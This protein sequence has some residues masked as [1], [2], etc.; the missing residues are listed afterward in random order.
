MVT[1]HITRGLPGCG[2]STFA[3]EWV[4]ENPE[5]RV[6]INLDDFRNMFDRYTVTSGPHAIRVVTARNAAVVAMLNAG[7]DVIVDDT[8]LPNKFV[9]ELHKIAVAADADFNVVDMT[10]V[11]VDVCIARDAARDRTVGEDVIRNYHNRFVKGRTYPLKVDIPESDKPVMAEPYIPDT[12]LPRTILCD[13]DGTV[14]LMNGRGP[15][16]ETRVSEDLPN[17]PV[18]DA[19]KAMHAAGHTVVFLSARTEGCKEDTA[20]WLDRHVGITYDNLLMR[21]VGDQR[22]DA[23]VKREIFDSYIRDHY[24]VIGVFDDRNQVVQMWRSLGLTVFQVAE[25]NF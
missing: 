14:A 4:A 25:G 17:Q 20:A 1:L 16:D 8:N 10:D 22:K 19:V 13:L 11:P 12:T 15:Y 21:N 2:K 3:Q 5:S 9:R 24:Q 7:Y 23:L 6:R 18:I